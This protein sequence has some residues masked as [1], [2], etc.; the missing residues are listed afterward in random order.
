MDRPTTGI[1]AAQISTKED[2]DIHVP[3]AV[4]S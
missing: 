3:L 2:A 4:R 1:L